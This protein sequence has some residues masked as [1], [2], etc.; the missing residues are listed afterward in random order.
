MSELWEGLVATALVGTD[1]KTPNLSNVEG[2]LGQLLTQLDSEEIN[3]QIL[4]AAGAIA[5][6]QKAGIQASEF[7]GQLPTPCPDD[8][9]PLCP[10]KV[11]GLLET[12][13][14]GTHNR[15]LPEL[16]TLIQSHG[17]RV[18]EQSI[19]MLL[20]LGRQRSE[21]RDRIRA[22]VGQRGQWLAQQNP[23]WSYMSGALT[24]IDSTGQIDHNLVAEQWETE[25]KATRLALLQQI[26][27]QEPDFARELLASSWKQDKAKE[28]AEF[29]NCLKIQLSE[30]DED[31]LEAAL[32]DRS[33]EVRAIAANILAALPTSQF[34]QRM[35]ERVKNLISSDST[36]SGLELTVTLPQADITEDGLVA[37]KSKNIGQRSSLLLQIVAAVPLSYWDVSPEQLIKA[38]HQKDTQSL[39]LMGWTSA[40]IR[41]NNQDWAATLIDHFSTTNRSDDYSKL[42]DLAK[43][44]SPS[45]QETKLE[46]W[47]RH[48][49]QGR[50][51]KE[52]RISIPHIIQVHPLPSLEFSQTL[53]NFFDIDLKDD[54]SRKSKKYPYHL[55]S[56]IYDLGYYLHP[57]SYTDA[58]KMV[59]QLNENNLDDQ[60]RKLLEDWLDILSFRHSMTQLF[61][62]S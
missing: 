6:S 53:L 44:L 31:F 4:G 62:D 30:T 27:E 42:A 24:G 7:S 51:W 50:D 28:R 26:R 57:D 60:R 11:H 35:V 59:T 23:A 48:L 45:A 33:K 39:L 3:H 52:W 16:L 46:H 5:V 40:A 34:C 13:V 58:S 12:V 54:M 25:T 41:Q 20:Q 43:L 37:T 32:T 55:R 17:M 29:L 15:V 19:P 38:T 18:S 56:L 1:R 10:A 14:A 61:T 36:S 9:Q 8:D 47:V 2:Q 22:I 21:L 49:C